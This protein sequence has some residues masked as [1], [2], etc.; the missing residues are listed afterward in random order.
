MKRSDA[1]RELDD[2]LAA[3]EAATGAGVCVRT[4]ADTWRDRTGKRL[5]SFEYML[6]TAPFCEAMK[7]KHMTMCRRWDSDYAFRKASGKS[8]P[9]VRTCHA[10]A[11]EI[12]IPLEHQGVL[13]GVVF[14]G[15]FRR[16]ASGPKELPHW[17][18][19]RLKQ[20]LAL[21]R[22][23]QSYLLDVVERMATR[24]LHAWGDRQA[25]IKAYIN[26]HLH[27]DVSLN[28][29][30]DHLGLSGSRTSHLVREVCGQSFRDLKE[31]Q[32]MKLARQ[33]LGSAHATVAWVAQQVGI[34]DANYF[35]RYF[36]QRQGVTP[37][38]YRRTAER[39]DNV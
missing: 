32:R 25:Q 1:V 15:P 34:A 16:V 37:S 7:S 6:H 17:R 8:D 26:R 30:A 33:L 11:D 28:D 5:L 35:S 4:T 10:G 21:S 3:F 36:R 18:R 13:V 27:D 14:V 22:L 24:G 2:A 23:L 31:D 19:D 12:I 39:M 9:F 38:A 20:H 29:L